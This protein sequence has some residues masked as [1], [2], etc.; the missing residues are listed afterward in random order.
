MGAM[1]RFFALLVACAG[2]AS[3]CY[4]GTTASQPPT[5]SDPGIEP[6]VIGRGP[7]IG[8]TWLADGS[9]L[10]GKVRG[11][12]GERLAVL[13]EDGTRESRVPLE[14]APGC[15]QTSYLAHGAL[16]DGRVGI[17]RECVREKYRG[18]VSHLIAYDV[19]SD[20]LAPSCATSHFRDP[21]R[22]EPYRAQGDRWRQ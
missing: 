18:I 16:P 2:F 5:F 6:M 12:D 14:A 7:Y 15:H 3:S 4:G 9:F 1:R 8:V 13:S 11:P 20:E 21:I 10:V 17:V 22:L 19:E